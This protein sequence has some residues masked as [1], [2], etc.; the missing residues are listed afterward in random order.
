MDKKMLVWC[1]AYYT[2]GLCMPIIPALDGLRQ[3]DGKFETSL[4]YITC[5]RSAWATY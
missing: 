2:I 4:D 1:R 3:E 5:A